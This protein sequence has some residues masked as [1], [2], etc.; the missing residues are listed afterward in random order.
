[1]AFAIDYPTA[2]RT[3]VGGAPLVALIGAHVPGWRDFN[4]TLVAIH[5]R[6]SLRSMR[7]SGPSPAGSRPVG[8]ECD[9]CAA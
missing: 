7:R 3:W 2:I 4:R 8:V 9:R 6:L 5:E 1:M